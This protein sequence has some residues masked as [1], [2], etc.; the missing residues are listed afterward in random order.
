MRITIHSC[1]IAAH[2]LEYLCLKTSQFEY[3]IPGVRSGLMGK[4]HPREL[5]PNIPDKTEE[6]K[7]PQSPLRLHVH[8]AGSL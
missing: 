3:C 6:N 7:G 4:K 8:R 2:S 1:Q 5:C